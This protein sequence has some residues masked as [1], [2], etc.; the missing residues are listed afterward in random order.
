ML[1]LVVLIVNVTQSRVPLGEGTL[2]KSVGD[3]LDCN[4]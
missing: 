1:T 3:C 2:R 4:N